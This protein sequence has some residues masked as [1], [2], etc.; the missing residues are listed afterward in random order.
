M[1]AAKMAPGALGRKPV[2]SMMQEDHDSADYSEVALLFSQSLF[3]LE[4]VHLQEI[5][6]ISYP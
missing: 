6:V 5:V 1:T 3:S 2:V 4:I